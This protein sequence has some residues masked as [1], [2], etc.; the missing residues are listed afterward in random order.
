MGT[1]HSRISEKPAQVVLSGNHSRASSLRPNPH[2]AA[3]GNQA[4][5]WRL[6]SSTIQPKLK[7]NQAGDKFEQEADRVA[8][9][10]AGMPD[11]DTFELPVGGE[12]VHSVQRMCTDCEEDL[13][14]KS[15]DSSS[16]SVDGP[17]EAQIDSLH[18]SGQPLSE[19]A[20][21]YFEP[22]FGRDFGDV[23]IHA[24]STG[25]ET[26]KSINA[27][28][29]TKGRDIVFGE[30]QYQPGTH[31]GRRLLAHE[32]THVVQ[33]GG[34]AGE[35]ARN[36][37]QQMLQ[38]TCGAPAIGTPVG[39]TPDASDPVGDL[40]LFRIDCD[41]FSPATEEAKV[42]DFADSMTAS[43]RVNVHGF[44]STDGDATYNHHLSC[45]RAL[46]AVGVL[47]AHGIGPSQIDTFEHGGTP[48][49]AAQRRSVVLE[50]QPGVSR[51]TVPQ[52]TAVVTTAPTPGVCGD[53]PPANIMNFVITWVLS[54]NSDA[55]NGGF[56]I[57]DVTFNWNVVDCT[58]TQVPNADPRTSPLRYFEAWRAAP[59]TAVLT[60]AATDTFSWPAQSPWDGGCTD[61]TVS[62]SATARFH[63]DVAALP[64]HMVTP[65][66]ATFAGGLQSSTV[67]PALGGNVSRPVTHELSFHWTCCPCSS[68][69]A[70]VD[71]HTP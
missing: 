41:E 32:L 6:S 66:L 35:L 67:D 63:D 23:R 8:E 62:I 53:P 40:V 16:G 11:P 44:A 70:V 18:G 60:P 49:P 57:Q 3:M 61:G 15:C 37:D 7:V 5:Q 9:V 58:G 12:S 20:R 56:V 68:S 29:Y 30:G 25:A 17:L 27:L 47:N 4:L 50:R 51:P 43:D 46:R 33:Q 21:T 48:G 65:N 28:A 71:S 59:G 38:R 55:T 36:P 69:A 34:S 24:N 54:R 13:H 52:L 45:A 31:A 42:V 14:R 64:A 19:S 2:N 1:S 10:V 22:R 39:C 26:A